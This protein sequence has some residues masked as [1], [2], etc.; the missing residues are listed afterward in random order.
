[1][2]TASTWLAVFCMGVCSAWSEEGNS[3]DDVRKGHHLATMLCTACHIAAS[4]Q[5]YAPTLSPPAPSFESI[6]Q[7]R[8]ISADSL[9]KFLTT[10][11]QGLDNP[12][13]MPNPNLADFQI[14]EIVAYLL[15]L[16]N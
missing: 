3:V 16:R 9:Q 4:D 12:K 11:H 5:S 15:S 7:R 13:G 10:T 8:E 1:M 14:K 6:A 2:R